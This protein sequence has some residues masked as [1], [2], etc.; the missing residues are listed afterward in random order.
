MI[1]VGFLFFREQL[2]E[3][4]H[5]YYIL[6]NA[7]TAGRRANHR[8]SFEK[9]SQIPQKSAFVEFGS[10][11]LYHTALF[12]KYRILDCLQKVN[13]TRAIRL[14]IGEED[15]RMLHFLCKKAEDGKK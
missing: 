7:G 5:C 9:K 14:R 2:A 13:K 8:I 11:G 12:D 3:K 6:S 10:T 1:A 4:S 15:K